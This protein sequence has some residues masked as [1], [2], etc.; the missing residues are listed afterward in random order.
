M[1]NKIIKVAFFNIYKKLNRNR[2]LDANL[3]GKMIVLL[4]KE[5]E[6]TRFRKY[7]KLVKQN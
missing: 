4:D 7:H 2:R 5:E 3:Q 6:E 1:M